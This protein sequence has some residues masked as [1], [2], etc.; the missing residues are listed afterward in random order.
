M[1]N[2]PDYDNLYFEEKKMHTPQVGD[3]FAR[4]DETKVSHR[5][6][7]SIYKCCDGDCLIHLAYLD[8]DNRISEEVIFLSAMNKH[9]KYLGKSKTNINDLFKTENE[10]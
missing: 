1:N 2:E 4:I 6:I 9:Y 5:R 3:I 10:E 8:E 7:T